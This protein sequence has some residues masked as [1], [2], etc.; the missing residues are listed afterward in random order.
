ML[1]RIPQKLPGVDIP[2]KSSIHNLVNTFKRRTSVLDTK[3]KRHIL[4]KEK[5]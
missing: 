3:R 2:A 1:K 4:A 5:Q